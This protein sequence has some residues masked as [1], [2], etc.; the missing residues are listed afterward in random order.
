MHH[1]RSSGQPQPGQPPTPHLGA[2]GPRA[3]A[4]RS[5]PHTQYR[6]P[7]LGSGTSPGQGQGSPP[8]PKAEAALKQHKPVVEAEGQHEALPNFLLPGTEELNSPS[9]PKNASLSLPGCRRPEPNVTWAV[10]FCS[11]SNAA[12][13]L[14]L[15]QHPS[16][17][18]AASF[19]A[20]FMQQSGA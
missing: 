17:S 8:V 5:F 18:K 10:P 13:A 2:E 12:A 14:G 19:A 20:S 6:L 9:C 3:L 1:W 4:P 7:F 15:S 16:C 11:A